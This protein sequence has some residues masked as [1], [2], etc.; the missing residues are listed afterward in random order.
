MPSKSSKLWK[1]NVRSSTATQ[2]IQAH[3]HNTRAPADLGEC[4]LRLLPLVCAIS[5][6]PI[7]VCMGLE[8]LC[9]GLDS[10]SYKYKCIY[11]LYVYTVY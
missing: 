9:R 2:Q 5:L 3:H 1:C 4:L 10:D 6:T 7:C 11:K 8:G